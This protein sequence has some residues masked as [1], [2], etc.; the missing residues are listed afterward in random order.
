MINKQILLIARPD[1]IPAPEHFS[2]VEADYPRLPDNGL[3]VQNRYLSID[4]AMRGWICDFNNYLPPVEIGAVMRSLAVGEVIASNN[5]EYKPGEKVT[6]WFGWQQFAGILPQQV[7]RKVLPS[8]GSLSASPGVLGLNGITAYEAL[9]EIGRPQKGETILVSTAAGGV[10]SLVGQ[11]ARL[12]GC[13]VIGLTGSDAKVAQ[14]VND[15]GYDVAINY[16]ATDSLTDA[17]AQ[18]AGQGIDIF[19]DNTGGEIADSV[20]PLMNL[21]G[22]V[23]QC[24]TSAVPSWNSVPLA[25][26]R[27]RYI[28]TKRLLQQG[29]VVF[30]C[31]PKWP[32]IIAALAQLLKNGD[33]SYQED[34]REGLNNAPDALADLYKGNNR[35]KTLVKVEH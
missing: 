21:N 23:I 8:E 29:F 34:V 31:L 10:G 24:G 22:R 6:G 25:P 32:K 2:L 19:F 4:P 16:K 12:A 3:I 28:L 33:I 35:G 5:P 1:N 27:E 18:A 14:S 26:R 7:L 11:L 9:A 15:F 13:R 17:V 20:F 30:D